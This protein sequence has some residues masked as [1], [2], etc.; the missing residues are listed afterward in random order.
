MKKVMIGLLV[1]IPIIIVVV[2]GMVTTFVSTRAHIAVEEIVFDKS[3]IELELSDDIYD[4]NN[5]VK[6]SVLPERASDK[7]F[8]WKIEGLKCFDGAY[9]K[10]QAQYK[11]DLAAYE[12]AHK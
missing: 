5:F 2:V 6:V 3:S 1:L 9:E 11:L 7:S 12:S 8:V 4:L 10:T